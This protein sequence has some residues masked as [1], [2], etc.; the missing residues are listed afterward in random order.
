[1]QKLHR[2][3]TE[4]IYNQIFHRLCSYNLLEIWWKTMSKT[5]PNSDVLATR[6][7]MKADKIC[8]LQSRLL[9]ERNI[10]IIQARGNEK[11]SGGC[12]ELWNIVGHH[13]WPTKKILHFKS[14]K[15]AKNT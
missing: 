5:I 10:I 3:F 7:A 6:D 14:S 15:T 2:S 4:V 1:M 8:L 9:W 12:Y 13:D 11:N